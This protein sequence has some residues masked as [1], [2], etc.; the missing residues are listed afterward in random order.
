M[1]VSEI[2]SKARLCPVVLK[3]DVVGAL[4]FGII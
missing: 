4:V 1:I 2:S 3:K